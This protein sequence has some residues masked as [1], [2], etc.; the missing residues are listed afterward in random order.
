MFPF[1]IATFALGTIWW[2]VVTILFFLAMFTCVEKENNFFSGLWLVLYLAFLQFIV[3]T[4]FLGSIQHDPVRVLLYVLGYLAV[5]FLW[6]F[7]KW[8][9][10]VSKKAEEHAASYK[11]ARRYFLTRMKETCS[12][13]LTR[14]GDDPSY[15]QSRMDDIEKY[16]KYLPV[17]NALGKITVDTQVPDILQDAWKDDHTAEKIP[18]VSKHKGKVAMW[19]VYWP[20]SLIWSLINDFVKKFVKTMIE[21]F[22]VIYDNITKLAYRNIEG[23]EDAFDSKK[24]V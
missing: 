6:S 2:Y 17:L 14:V 1:L 10:F 19:V 16:K 8:W 11:E 24:K 7:V 22:K 12:A 9:L 20:I 4:D 5:G 23:V 13:W 15:A 18:K 3:K 21:Q